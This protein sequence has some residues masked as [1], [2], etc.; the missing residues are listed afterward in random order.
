MHS[1]TH[2]RSVSRRFRLGAAAC[3]TAMLLSPILISLAGCNA[4]EGLGED[5]QE[6]SDNTKE[7]L[8]D[9]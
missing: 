6:A 8:S 5:L 2:A 9:E 4:V 1:P 3:V 7:A